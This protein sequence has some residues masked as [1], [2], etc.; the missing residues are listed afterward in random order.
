LDFGLAASDPAETGLEDLHLDL[1]SKFELFESLKNQEERK[2]L[3]AKEPIEVKRSEPYNIIYKPYA[4][5]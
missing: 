5:M 2:G 1:K 4:N 3:I